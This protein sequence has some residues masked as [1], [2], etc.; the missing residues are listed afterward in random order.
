ME[1]TPLFN[2][3]SNV[4]YTAP[5]YLLF[6]R[7]GTLIAQPFDAATLKPS[8]DPVALADNLAQG[9]Y[10]HRMEFSASNTGMLAYRSVNLD[11]HIAWVDQSGTVLESF[12]ETGRYNNLALSPDGSRVAF[13]KR[14]ADGRTGDLWVLDL[15]RNVT[16]RL[17]FHPGAVFRPVW[18]PD[19]ATIAYSSAHEGSTAVVYL[20]RL[21]GPGDETP[22]FS[23]GTEC[24]SQGFSPDGRD[25]LVQC[26][27]DGRLGAWMV[28]LDDSAKARRLT[29]SRGDVDDAR[30][31]PTDSGSATS[32]PR[33]GGVR[34][35]S[36][37]SGLPGKRCWCRRAVAS[38]HSGVPTAGESTT[39]TTAAGSTR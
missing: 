32:P 35:T 3:I 1:V 37:T 7:S 22:V 8:G 9:N 25:L 20:K 17:T 19:G 26:Y 10:G 16:S 15:T 23:D 4:V 33:R 5:G 39:S 18:S 21:D 36:R 28:P 6:A 2:M 13:G 11:S 38:T 12:G 14:D 24:G 31:S 34:S 30:P 27:A 29:L